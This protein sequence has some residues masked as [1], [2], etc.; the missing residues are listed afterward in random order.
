MPLSHPTAS[1][2]HEE[3]TNVSN[4]TREFEKLIADE[5]KKEKELIEG[6]IPDRGTS[7]STDESSDDEVS[8][9]S[10]NLRARSS[11]PCIDSYGKK[12]P[13]KKQKKINGKFPSRST[14]DKNGK[15]KKKMT[16]TPEFYE[17]EWK[18]RE[19]SPYPRRHSEMIVGKSASEIMRFV[20]PASKKS[21]GFPGSKTKRISPSRK[22]S[23]NKRKLDAIQEND[24][25]S[26]HKKLKT[27]IKIPSREQRAAHKGRRNGSAEPSSSSSSSS[28]EE[29]ELAEDDLY[30][31]EEDKL[32]SSTVKKKKR[33]RGGKDLG[34]RRQSAEATISPSTA[35]YLNSF[36]APPAGRYASSGNISEKELAVLTA[37]ASATA[38]SS[39]LGSSSA[40][41]SNAPSSSSSS[42]Q[43]DPKEDAEPGWEIK[44]RTP[45]SSRSLSHASSR[46]NTPPLA[47]RRPPS[48]RPPLRRENSGI[49]PNAFIVGMPA[50]SSLPTPESAMQL[51][52]SSLPVSRDEVTAEGKSQAM[53]QS[54]LSSAEEDELDTDEDEIELGIISPEKPRLSTLTDMDENEGSLLEETWPEIEKMPC[55]PEDIAFPPQNTVTERPYGLGSLQAGTSMG[56]ED[57]PSNST[58]SPSPTRRLMIA[59]DLIDDAGE[60]AEAAQNEAAI[61]R[62]RESLRRDLVTGEVPEPD[63]N[64]VRQLFEQ[65]E[66]VVHQPTPT[67]ELPPPATKPN[68]SMKSG[69]CSIVPSFPKAG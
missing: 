2:M 21:F 27:I 46:S 4:V 34:H 37:M 5:E 14:G 41:P 49:H 22:S 69:G 39:H 45:F 62:L 43:V 16:K 11:T 64:F 25:L 28:E 18:R 44:A 15:R 55:S 36:R 8:E 61:R 30:K 23:S 17:E 38:S 6:Y 20:L 50:G 3:L 60:E 32:R 12:N 63:I 59:C 56:M 58:S 9:K 51:H 42:M 54:S 68:K 40:Y 26:I 66:M 29:D 53:A 35:K 7:D 48:D 19:D 33:S 13:K 10:Y 57:N 67:G 1:N 24:D 47:S 65:C 52:S 31:P